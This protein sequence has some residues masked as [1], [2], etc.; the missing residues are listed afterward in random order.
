MDIFKTT[1]RTLGTVTQNDDLYTIS[2][3][4]VIPLGNGASSTDAAIVYI[5][6][7]P[8]GMTQSIGSKI[9]GTSTPLQSV[10]PSY[11]P[12]ATEGSEC[13]ALVTSLSWAD[14]N[15]AQGYEWLQLN[16]GASIVYFVSGV[17]TSSE[18]DFNDPF[19]ATEVNNACCWE[20]SYQA[21]NNPF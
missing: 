14:N 10:T 21:G 18:T 9:G 13:A 7:K 2:K 5:N 12:Y 16:V 3:N 15:L 17:L 8:T 1:L 11:F 4:S 20:G 19:A 6:I